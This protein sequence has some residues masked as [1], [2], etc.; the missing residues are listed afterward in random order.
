[1][2][3]I[4]CAGR[5][6]TKVNTSMQIDTNLDLLSLGDT[7]PVNDAWM[8]NSPL[9]FSFALFPSNKVCSFTQSREELRDYLKTFCI[10]TGIYDFSLQ[11]TCQKQPLLHILTGHC[12]LAAGF[13]AQVNTN[14]SSGKLVPA[15]LAHHMKCLLNPS[16]RIYFTYP[17]D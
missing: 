15:N 2:T 4:T 9:P 3:T 13:L 10:K 14:Y 8:S 5:E 1:M 17:S 7:I 6:H 16:Y 12:F 11:P